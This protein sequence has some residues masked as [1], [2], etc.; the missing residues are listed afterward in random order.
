MLTTLKQKT[1][2]SRAAVLVVD[3]QNDF[4]HEN[5]IIA[6]QGRNMAFKKAMAPRLA[7]FLDTARRNRVPVIFIRQVNIR[8]SLSEVAMEQKRRT[9]PKAGGLICAEG[10]WGAEYYMVSPK[11]GEA[12]VTKHRYSGFNGTDLDLILRSMKVRSIILTGVATNACVETTARDGFM[13]DYYVV[14]LSD[15]T[16][17]S[18]VEDQEATLRNIRTYFGVVVDSKEVIACWTKR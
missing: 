10:S 7:R 8:Q 12:V 6:R 13:N 3:M 9:Q 4:C 15:C 14:L 11:P 1:D 5:G 2:P 16:A 18:T 17:T